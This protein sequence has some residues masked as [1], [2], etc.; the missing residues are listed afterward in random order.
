[1]RTLAILPIKRFDDAKQRLESALGRGAR[2]ALAQA[3]FTDVVAALRRVRRIEAVAVVT[4]DTVAE[5]AA[6]ADG[7]LVIRDTAQA[8]QSRAAAL[9]VEHAVGA[10]FDRAVLV[11]GDTPL[12]DPGELDRA[13]YRAEA[14]AVAAVVVPDRHGTGTNALVLRPPD[15]I[16]ASFGPGSR[17]RHEAAARAAGLSWRT[18]EIESL[19]GDVD[20]PQDLELLSAALERRRGQAPATRGALRQLD[21]LGAAGPRARAGAAEAPA[22]EA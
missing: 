8:G 18:E 1:M 7:L 16:P 5:A 11:P 2:R 20:T 15:A 17:G 12:M 21:R 13:L 22:I 3:M 14:D 19:S 4:A 9:G 6:R 10:G